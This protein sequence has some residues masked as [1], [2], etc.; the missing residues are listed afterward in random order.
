M[1]AKC[2]FFVNGFLAIQYMSSERE[3]FGYDFNLYDLNPLKSYCLLARRKP[4]VWHFW[5]QI[6][7]SDVVM[8][9]HLDGRKVERVLTQSRDRRHVSNWKLG[10]PFLGK[11]FSGGSVVKTPPATAGDAGS[12]PGSA[13]SPGERNGNP[14]QYSCMKNPTKR[15]AQQAIVHGVAKE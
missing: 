10:V 4:E 9:P 6:S 5:L 12:I 1:L 13:R 2:R 15:G 11:G 14:L 8:W 3:G 7:W